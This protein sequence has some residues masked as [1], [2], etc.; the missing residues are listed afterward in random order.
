MMDSPG[1]KDDQEETDRT[2]LRQCRHPKSTGA[3]NVRKPKQDLP[4]DLDPKDL[5]EREESLERT[6]M[7]DKED[8]LDDLAQLEDQA[9]QERPE[10]QGLPVAPEHSE[11]YQAPLEDQDHQAQ[12]GP[13]DNPVDLDNLEEAAQ[14]DLLEL[15]VILVPPDRPE[16]LEATAI[17]ELREIK[18]TRDRA[19]IVHLREQLPDI[20]RSELLKRI[21]DCLEHN[22]ARIGCLITVNSPIVCLILRIYRLVQKL[23]SIC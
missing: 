1:N 2:H 3:S 15:P 23:R 8:N 20:K 14:W 4:V 10:I 6:L 11:M 18:A 17:K 9:A 5:R 19:I 12:Q 16:S 21:K 22:T 7:G 13:L